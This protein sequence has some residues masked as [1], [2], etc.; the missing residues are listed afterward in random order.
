[1]RSAE[2][3]GGVGGGMRGGKFF[4]PFQSGRPSKWPKYKFF[5][6]LRHFLT[7]NEKTEATFKKGIDKTKLFHFINFF[8]F[9][10]GSPPK[11]PKCE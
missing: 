4:F 8:P 7:E 1:M 9:Q 11:W 10:S 6:I 5:G 2:L 3:N